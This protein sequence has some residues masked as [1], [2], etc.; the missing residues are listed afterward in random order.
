VGVVVVKGF[1]ILLFVSGA[2]EDILDEKDLGVNKIDDLDS[3]W[4]VNLFKFKLKG[5]LSFGDVLACEQK[6]GAGERTILIEF[7][8]LSPLQKVGAGWVERCPFFVVVC[9]DLTD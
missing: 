8:L 9:E 2:G 7:W 5:L 1:V 6:V 4:E 3:F